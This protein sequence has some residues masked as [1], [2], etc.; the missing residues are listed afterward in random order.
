MGKE[1][2]REEGGRWGRRVVGGREWERRVGASAVGR[3]GVRKESGGG[4]EGGR[5]GVG[6]SAH[7]PLT[8]SKTSCFSVLLIS[9]LF[10][11]YSSHIRPSLAAP[12]VKI[13]SN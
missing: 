3:K 7:L 4:G 2:G 10:L 12:A 6:A 8:Y 11:V 1:G 5:K 13:A 9:F